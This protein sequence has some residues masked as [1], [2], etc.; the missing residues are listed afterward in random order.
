MS[1]RTSTFEQKRS[2]LLNAM[3]GG[4][5]QKPVTKVIPFTNDDV[6]VF[7][8]KLAEFEERSRKIRVVVG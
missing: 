5:N 6:P 7:L 8:E 2:K 1:Q 4:C 3:S